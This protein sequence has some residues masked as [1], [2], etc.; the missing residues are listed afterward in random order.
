M[1]VF[2]AMVKLKTYIENC[3]TE[4]MKVAAKNDFVEAIKEYI[5]DGYT[6]GRR[7]QLPFEISELSRIPKKEL[8][9]LRKMLENA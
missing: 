2:D 6:W 1:S 4:D 9:R 8:H 7:H 3:P 5:N